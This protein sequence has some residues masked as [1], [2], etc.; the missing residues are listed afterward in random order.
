MDSKVDTKPA[1]WE[2]EFP[3]WLTVQFTVHFSVKAHG[4]GWMQ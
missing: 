2:R 1:F 4:F 3:Q